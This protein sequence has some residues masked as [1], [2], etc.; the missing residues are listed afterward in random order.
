MRL[1][2]FLMILFA[3]TPAAAT[4]YVVN[5]GPGS[6]TSP[7]A[8]GP[9][10]R[11]YGQFTLDEPTQVTGINFYGSVTTSGNALFNINDGGLNQP[12][13]FL[14]SETRFIEA[15]GEG[16]YGISGLNLDLGAG[17][18]WVGV[19]SDGGS[20]TALHY[21]DAAAPLGNEAYYTPLGGYTDVDSANLAWQIT[22]VAA[23]APEPGTWLMMIFGFGF[24][25]IALRRQN[26]KRSAKCLASAKP[27]HPCGS[28]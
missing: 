25:G 16:W 17:T 27:A 12:N 8:L 15:G 20:L 14:L 28:R 4:H 11:T 24:A 13:I 23:A 21:G 9:Q 2:L 18:Y 19:G 26:A 22:G 1:L 5:T 10:A 7:L 3:A 6:A